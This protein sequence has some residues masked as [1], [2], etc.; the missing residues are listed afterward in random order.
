MSSSFHKILLIYF[1]GQFE[2][3]LNECTASSLALTITLK[4]LSAIYYSSQDT[5]ITDIEDTKIINGR[6]QRRLKLQ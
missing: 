2:V 4:S 3:N 1:T 5:E 6:T